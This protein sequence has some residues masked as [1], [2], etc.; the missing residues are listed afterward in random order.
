MRYVIHFTDG[1]TQTVTSHGMSAEAFIEEFFEAKI[2]VMLGSN[3]KPV[4]VVH[5]N[6]VT[7]IEVQDV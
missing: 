1:T 3:N 6:N 7:F 5:T 2:Y 4:L